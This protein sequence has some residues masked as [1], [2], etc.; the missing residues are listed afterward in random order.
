VWY[1]ST[2]LRV[3]VGGGLPGIANSISDNNRV[4]GH[5]RPLGTTFTT[6]FTLTTLGDFGALP[7]APYNGGSAVGVNTCGTIVG[8][9]AG[10]YPVPYP[11]PVVWLARGTGCDTFQAPPA[12]PNI[13]P[14]FSNSS[15]RTAT[16]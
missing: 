9:A 13:P 10:P 3:A 6:P 11:L 7:I 5:V 16:P 14:L 15:A 1:Q 4:V 2:G 8:V 12:P